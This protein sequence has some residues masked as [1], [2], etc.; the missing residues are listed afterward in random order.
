MIIIHTFHMYDEVQGRKPPN[1]EMS[2][3]ERTKKRRYD[4][5]NATG[6]LRPGERSASLENCQKEL[7]FVD[8]ANLDLITMRIKQIDA[9]LGLLKEQITELKRI[10]NNLNQGQKGDKDNTI[11]LL[12][13]AASQPP[14]IMVEQSLYHSSSSK[15]RKGESWCIGD[16]PLPPYR[17]RSGRNPELSVEETVAKD[18]TGTN[19]TQF[20]KAAVPVTVIEAKGH[21]VGFI[22]FRDEQMPLLID[23]YPKSNRGKILGDLA[24]QW[25]RMSDQ[26]RKVYEVPSLVT[27]AATSVTKWLSTALR[28]APNSSL[29]RQ[30]LSQS[31]VDT[32]GD[33]LDEG[34][35]D[36]ETELMLLESLDDDDDVRSET[37]L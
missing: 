32:M 17:E 3:I 29:A 21:R 33:I 30:P 26:E 34:K 8:K 35:S 28:A 27:P 4:S 25:K 1:T 11:L 2:L 14:R 36:E 22:N 13:E 37:G 12:A 9:T 6:V 15:N 20:V 19:L 24:A 16:A 7:S 18:D 31:A 10:R 23:G 5:P